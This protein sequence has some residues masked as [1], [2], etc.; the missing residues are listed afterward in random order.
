MGAW[1]AS[2]WT[3]T[4]PNLLANVLWVPVV[5]VHHRVMARRIRALH[6]HVTVLH[7]RHEQLLIRHALG[8]ATGAEQEGVTS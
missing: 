5:W 6:R 3:A 2:T 4:W 7:D 1:L 8:P